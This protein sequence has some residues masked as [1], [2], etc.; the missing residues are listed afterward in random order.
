MKCYVKDDSNGFY[1]KACEWPAGKTI[2]DNF[3]DSYFVSDIK[4]ATPLDAETAKDLCEKI[5]TVF[6]DATVS[7]EVIDE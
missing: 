4:A 5:K 6:K 2:I 1:Y 3:Q 7:V